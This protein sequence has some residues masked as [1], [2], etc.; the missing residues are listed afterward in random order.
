MYHETFSQIMCKFVFEGEIIR[1]CTFF[2]WASFR[3]QRSA[4]YVFDHMQNMNY[5]A[6]CVLQ[7][8]LNIVW[9]HY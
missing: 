9:I 8:T 5:K 1:Y 6:K 4:Y 7:Q 3:S 2:M